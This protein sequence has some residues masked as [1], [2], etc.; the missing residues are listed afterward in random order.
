[1]RRYLFLMTILALLAVSAIIPE[2]RKVMLMQARYLA[3]ARI[4]PGFSYTS[5]FDSSIPSALAR[6]ADISLEN[7]W[8]TWIARGQLDYPRA[9]GYCR[10]A[11]N[12]APNQPE[13][14]AAAIEAIGYRAPYDR[15]EMGRGY[16]N[17]QMDPKIGR[18]M[19]EAGEK[20]SQADPNNAFFGMV[21]AYALFGMHKD[22]EALEA[23]KVAGRKSDYTS[24]HSAAGRYARRYMRAAG[25]PEMECCIAGL[26]GCDAYLDYITKA[27]QMTAWYA[28]CSLGAGQPAQTKQL[29]DAV[30]NVGSLMHRHA[31]SGTEYLASTRTEWSVG[32]VVPK[33]PLPPGRD[34]KE[35]D[36]LRA[37][38]ISKFLAAKG[39]SGLAVSWNEEMRLG[40][41]F[42][43][44]WNPDLLGHPLFVSGCVM[45]A[46]Q[47]ASISLAMFIVT[48]ILVGL[49]SLILRRRS[50]PLLPTRWTHAVPTVLGLG[51]CLG[52]IA[53]F[54][55][56]Q[57]TEFW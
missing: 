2:S 37:Q 35:E 49:L 4:Y 14:Y 51:S 15:P 43:D 34:D 13:T 29:L 28:K 40:Q 5:F 48:S 10:K 8:Q 1:M 3:T 52:V 19:L 6:N 38:Q 22:K 47:V 33:D 45:A 27:C 31:H 20:G 56:H 46:A 9:R 44:R 25:F 17:R 30:L 36:R 16:G 57:F 32:K 50:T 11:V 18:S 12:A 26:G 55:Y 54:T 23:V 41:V 24:Y 53:W 7:E 21:Q 39:W 42:R